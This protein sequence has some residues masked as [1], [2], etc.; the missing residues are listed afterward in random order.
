MT[1]ISRPQQFFSEIELL[2]HEGKYE[3]A[4]ARLA[5]RLDQHPRDRES[6]LYLLLVNATLHGALSYEDEIYRLRNLGD[7]GDTEREIVRRLF[8]LAFESAEK[9]G[10]EKQA[11]DYQRL[12]RR[13]LLN[14]PLDHSLPKHGNA[15][16]PTNEARASAPMENALPPTGGLAPGRLS[17][18]RQAW[19]SN[20]KLKPSVRLLAEV[21]AFGLLIAPILYFLVTHDNLANDIAYYT[22]ATPPPLMAGNSV[23]VSEKI[24]LSGSGDTDS[25]KSDTVQKIVADE[26]SSLQQ[27]YDKWVRKNPNIMGSLLVKM[28]MDTAGNVVKVDE[29][30]SR[31][32]DPGFRNAALDELRKWK[33]PNANVG[34]AEF[35][36][37]LLFVPQDMAPAA[38]ARWE[39]TLKP[40]PPRAKVTFP[41]NADAGSTKKLENPIAFMIPW[42]FVLLVIAIVFWAISLFLVA[43]AAKI[44]Q[45]ALGEQEGI[46]NPHS[47]VDISQLLSCLFVLLW[48]ARELF[49]TQPTQDPFHLVLQLL[50]K[51]E[52]LTP[53]ILL[54]VFPP[55]IVGMVKLITALGITRVEITSEIERRNRL[56]VNTVFIALHLIV[57][58]GATMVLARSLL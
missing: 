37:P 41:I 42:N 19:S 15:A 20:L 39:R 57:A 24:A 10:S 3:D 5:K 25:V 32:S 11:W 26:L 21:V 38:I 58:L 51:P 28:K 7:L 1:E 49:S 43:E 22:K 45:W 31:L 33:F 48:F 50:V 4:K 36:I 35:T 14:Q 13:L 46:L 53:G 23:L 8:L 16:W 30:S 17:R 52:L 29:V 54:A 18:F 44:Q 56:W 27:V 40:S 2:L 34:A 47:G 55:L 6:T 9:D 12:L